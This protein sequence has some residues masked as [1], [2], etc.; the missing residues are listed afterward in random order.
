MDPGFH[1]YNGAKPWQDHFRRTPAHNTVRIDGR[2]QA[3]HIG[4]MNWSHAYTATLEGRDLRSPNSWAVG[5]HDGYRSLPQGPV[6]HR[7]AIWV[8]ERGYIVVCDELE[9]AGSHDVELTF[10][11]APGRLV[12]GDTHTSFDD[13]A[14]L[15]WFAKGELTP[16]IH[17]GGAAPDAGWIAPSLGVKTAAPRLVLACSATLPATIVT[18]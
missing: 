18:F 10:Q 17:E 12:L 5:S 3:M 13:A 7:R 1:C 2:D 14:D 15:Y 16:G 8:R 11:F 4:K 9:G 6:L